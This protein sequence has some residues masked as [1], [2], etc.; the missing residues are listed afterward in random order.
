[1]DAPFSAGNAYLAVHSTDVA[2]FANAEVAD[3]P[4][5][6]NAEGLGVE[7]LS[8]RVVGR[9]VAWWRRIF[10]RPKSDG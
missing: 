10:H 1:M 5:H 2:T 3:D 9:L 6:V 7:P 8:Y 4:R